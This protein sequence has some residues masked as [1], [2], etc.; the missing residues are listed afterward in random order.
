MNAPIL[1]SIDS[2]VDATL[3]PVAAL[4]ARVEAIRAQGEVYAAK[5]A[6][7][8]D[9]RIDAGRVDAADALFDLPAPR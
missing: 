1:R 6:A 8:Y 3:A 9:A 7:R 5:V 2:H 4:R